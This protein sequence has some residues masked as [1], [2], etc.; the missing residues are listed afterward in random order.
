[1][2]HSRDGAQ[3]HVCTIGVVYETTADQLREILAAIREILDAHEK[4]LPNSEVR[5]SSFAE[6]SLQI[7]LMY[8]VNPPQYYLDVVSEVNLRIKDRFDG[9]GWSMAFPSLSLYVEK[10]GVPGF[11]SR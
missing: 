6:S 10:T 5:F 4:I 2:N 8:W 11:V 9:E 1:M 7:S 3:R